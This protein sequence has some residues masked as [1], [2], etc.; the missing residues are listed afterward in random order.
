MFGKFAELIMDW[1]RPH[2][3]QLMDAAYMALLPH[4]NYRRNEHHRL[5]THALF[6]NLT[7]HYPT[8]VA[9]PGLLDMGLG[10]ASAEIRS[11]DEVK[12]YQERA[13]PG[14]WDREM[15][16]LDIAKV[17]QLEK[18]GRIIV[19]TLWIAVGLSNLPQIWIAKPLLIEKMCVDLQRLTVAYDPHWRDTLRR[20]TAC[21]PVKTEA[22]GMLLAALV[23]KQSRET[24]S[25]AG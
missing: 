11:I 2:M 17:E 10:F 4:K 8:D 24:A 15:A 14:G 23:V 6:V 20:A 16:S 18:Y 7:P 9:Q 13:C 12:A 22:E 21:R 5:E 1:Q 25:L 3:G 19:G